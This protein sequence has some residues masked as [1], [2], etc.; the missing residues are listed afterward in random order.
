[1]PM[2]DLSLSTFSAPTG[3]TSPW[4]LV[5]PALALLTALVLAPLLLV[6]ATS[7]TDWQLGGA[8]ANFVGLA[9][10]QAL[11]GDPDF[12]R[13]ASNSARYIAMVVPCTTLLGLTAALL[14]ARLTHGAGFYRMIFF[15]PS[16][17]T[18]AAMAVAWQMLLSPSVGAVP[19]ILRL[20]G[21]APGNWL[22]DPDLALPM[23]A[24]IGIWAEFGFAMLFFLAGLKTL[25]REIGEAAAL[26]GL[27]HPLDRLWHVILPHL[28][29]ITLFTVVFSTLHALRVFDTVAIITR[30]GPEKTTLVMLYFIYQEGFSLFRTHLAA[31]A[32]VLFIL[33]VLILSLIQMRLGRPG[34]GR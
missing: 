10:Y 18:L 14:I 22:Q 19:Q 9:S 17:A 12:L 26:D 2:T 31:S 8:R 28:A 20:M 27:S 13:A 30:G 24:L 21:F 23:L 1:M 25:P 33:V 11:L 15:M 32:S 34:A 7:F 6:V 29:P 3:R 5:A 4:L 16:V